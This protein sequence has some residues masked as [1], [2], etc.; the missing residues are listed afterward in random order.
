MCSKQW[1]WWI[2]ICPALPRALGTQFFGTVPRPIAVGCSLREGHQGPSHDRPR[3]GRPGPGLGA[4]SGAGIPRA[5]RA[6][7]L[8]SAPLRVP[9]PDCPRSRGCK[10]EQHLS[11]SGIVH[12]KG[13]CLST[14][15]GR[16]VVW[17]V[18]SVVSL[19]R[20]VAPTRQL[21]SVGGGCAWAPRLPVPPTQILRGVAGPTRT[22]SQCLCVLAGGGGG[23]SPP[24]C[25]VFRPNRPPHG[26]LA[27]PTAKG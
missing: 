15:T 13:C 2:P 17:L 18:W 23:S 20:G 12:S 7:S 10:A 1:P 16:S 11:D 3:Q 21:G 5:A 6:H 4:E 27:P 26:F 25:L 9:G 22:Q 24:P 8:P 19:H 14:Q